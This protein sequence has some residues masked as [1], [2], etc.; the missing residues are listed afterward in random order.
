M[1][2]DPAEGHTN[3]PEKQSTATFPG[4]HLYLPLPAENSQHP[5]GLIPLHP[6][7]V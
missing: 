1:V 4:R 6:S 3:S 2:A 7:P 5:K